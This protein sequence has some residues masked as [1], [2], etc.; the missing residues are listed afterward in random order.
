M[1]LTEKFTIKK[2]KSG[3]LVYPVPLIV[4]EKVRAGDIIFVHGT[5]FVSSLIEFGEQSYI[6]HVGVAISNT[7]M[8][9]AVYGV[10]TH[11]RPINYEHMIIKRCNEVVNRRERAIVFLA[12]KIFNHKKYNT[13]GV[14]GWGIRLII[15]RLFGLRLFPDL[16]D[17]PNEFFCSQEV[18]TIFDCAGIKLVT[19]ED[20][21]GDVTPAMLFRSDKLVE[22]LTYGVP[23]GSIF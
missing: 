23:N 14:I 5:S 21:V 15:K 6:S 12:T 4:Q 22:V 18:D 7:E 11:I 13:M 17:V 20:A 16:F 9:E 3:R 8:S 2:E 1:K 10:G 19:N